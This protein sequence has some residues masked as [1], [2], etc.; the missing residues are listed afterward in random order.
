MLQNALVNVSNGRLELEFRSFHEHFICSKLSHVS[1][2]EL[3]VSKNLIQRTSQ[4]VKWTSGARVMLNWMLHGWQKYGFRSTHLC[5]M[6]DLARG[7]G[8]GPP[9]PLPP[10]PKSRG[11]Q[12]PVRS[13]SLWVAIPE[14]GK[15]ILSSIGSMES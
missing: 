13:L 7:G 1:M 15:L 4:R 14:I 10:P 9:F 3:L 12:L 11:T 2:L 8:R 5:K 6:P